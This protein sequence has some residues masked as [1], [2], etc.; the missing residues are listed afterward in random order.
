LLQSV[1]VGVQRAESYRGSVGEE[2]LDAAA[3]PLAGPH[4]NATSYGR[5]M[6]EILRS[7]VPLLRDL[8]VVVEWRTISATEEFFGVTKAIHDGLLGGGGGLSEAEWRPTWGRLRTSP[9]SGA[10]AGRG[11]ARTRPPQVPAAAPGRR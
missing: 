5:G 2:V 4:V 8:G 6:A 11:R 7:E 1:D 10:G 9:G 3:R